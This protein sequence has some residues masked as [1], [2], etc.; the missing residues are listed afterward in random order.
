MNLG[1][2]K[3]MN[4]PNFWCDVCEKKAHSTGY[5]AM[6]SDRKLEVARETLET[7]SMR[8]WTIYRDLDK[9]A[10]REMLYNL[11]NEIQKVLGD[12]K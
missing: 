6:E 1:K 8:I 11:N 10:Q 2:D 12:T 4:N 7:I 5:H 9:V 3:L